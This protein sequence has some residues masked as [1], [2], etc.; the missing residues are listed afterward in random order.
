MP[1]PIGP[2]VKKLIATRMST[3]AVPAGGGINDAINFILKPGAMAEGFRKASQWVQDALQVVRLAQEP[4]P[5]KV[6]TDEEIAGE[7]LRRV[8]ERRARK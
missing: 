7:L 8:E 4:N 6:A 1:T 3:E 5:W 2:N